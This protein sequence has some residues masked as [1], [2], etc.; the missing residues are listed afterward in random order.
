M[1]ATQQPGISAPLSLLI[2]LS[3]GVVWM[4]IASLIIRS[5][6][7]LAWS[8]TEASSHLMGQRL[9]QACS[10]VAD[11]SVSC[12]LHASLCSLSLV[13]RRLVVSPMYALPQEQGTL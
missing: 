5:G 1:V 8:N 13:S 10:A 6:E 3:I 9:F 4:W 7:F 12:F 11:L 2:N